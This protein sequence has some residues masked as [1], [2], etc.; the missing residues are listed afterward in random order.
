MG[1]VRQK[2]GKR[3][4]NCANPSSTVE[5]PLTNAASERKAEAECEINSEQASAPSQ[6]RLDL[7]PG[8]HRAR[9]GSRPGARP[10]VQRAVWRLCSS[11]CVCA[12]VRVRYCLVPAERG[13]A[14]GERVRHA[15]RALSRPPPTTLTLKIFI[16]GRCCCCCLGGRCAQSCPTR[17]VS[18]SSPRTATLLARLAQ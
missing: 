6:M 17:S 14:S 15:T 11:L 8:A 10:R 7:C 2:R 18:A 13:E 1:F 9:T 5:C 4:A 3:E 12:P 16:P